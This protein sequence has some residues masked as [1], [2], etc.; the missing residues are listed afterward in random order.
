MSDFRV[1]MFRG[2]MI[3]GGLFFRGLLGDVLND[4]R[5]GILFLVIGEV[6]FRGYFG[7]FY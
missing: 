3:V 1:F 6:E 2:F 5:G 4:L 7:L